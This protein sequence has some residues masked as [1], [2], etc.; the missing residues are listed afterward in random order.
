MSAG[1][2]V[3]RGRRGEGGPE[4]EL[5]YAGATGGGKDDAGDREREE[6]GGLTGDRGD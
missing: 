3:G 4:R 5:R 2:R 6:A 1:A